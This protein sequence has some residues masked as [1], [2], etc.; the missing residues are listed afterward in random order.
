M[1]VKGKV[2]LVTGGGSGIGRELVLNL[3]SKGAKV[4]A[5]DVNW[6]ALKETLSISRA[7]DSSLSL[8]AVDITNKT[9]VEELVGRAIAQN[10]PIDAIINNAG[11]IQPFVD[12]KDLDHQTIKKVIDVNLYGTLFVTK[13][14]LP[15]LI[16]RPEAHIVNISSMGG[17]LPVPGQTVYGATKAAVK[18]LTEGLHSE[19]Q[20]TNVHVSV[21]F[22]GAV[23]TNIT[24]N[25]GVTMVTMQQ[26]GKAPDPSKVLTPARA[27]EI[28]IKGIENNE[29][30]V[31]VGSD[32]KFLGIFNRISP[33]TAAS[34]INKQM[35]KYGITRQ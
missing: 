19:L 34:F 33:K 15:H 25:S 26:T 22:P 3:L 16:S 31:Y 23:A 10:G 6:T 20:H 12:L 7:P 13:A 14:F 8:F 9:A 28:I 27:A 29:Y 32:A 30:Q 11:I 18:L 21:V 35:K 5:V 4:I 2:I 24:A 1:K 17:F